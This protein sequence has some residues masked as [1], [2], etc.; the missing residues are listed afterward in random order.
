MRQAS[1]GEQKSA[2]IRYALD[3]ARAL[4]DESAPT[5]MLLDDVAA[6]LDQGKREALLGELSALGI[7]IWMTGADPAHF[8]VLGA[9]A[10]W[11]EVTKPAEDSQVERANHGRVDEDS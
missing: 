1:T 3:C 10:E 9:C 11:Y 6:H 4:A 8:A 5:V 7:Q 2:L